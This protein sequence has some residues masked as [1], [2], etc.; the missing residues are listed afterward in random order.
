MRF[1]KAMVFLFNRVPVSMGAVGAS[2]P[3][4]FE[5]VGD[6]PL[7][8]G[9]FSHISIIFHKN[10]MKNVMNLVKPWQ[11]EISSTHSSEFLTGS[12]LKKSTPKSSKF[13]VSCY[14][15][16][17]KTN[18]RK[19]SQDTWFTRFTLY[20]LLKVGSKYVVAWREISSGFVIPQRPRADAHCIGRG[21]SFKNNFNSWCLA[22]F[23]LGRIC[24]AGVPSEFL[25]DG[26][27]RKLSNSYTKIT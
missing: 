25:I 4:V 23:S 17:N 1:F 8:F 13:N 27:W 10:W 15:N 9:N 3:T 6:T 21:S 2:A 5:N 12:L 16:S 14:L 26:D 18:L 20:I 24:S 19:H 22:T 11:K 7:V